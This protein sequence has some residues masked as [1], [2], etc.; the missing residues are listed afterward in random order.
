[1]CGWLAGLR[2]NEALDLDWQEKDK[3]P[4]LDLAHSR[5]VF[6]FDAVDG[7]GQREVC[8]ITVSARARDLAQAADV[9]LTMKSLRRGFGCR[10]AVRPPAQVL[11]KLTRHANINTTLDYYA[12]VDDAVMEAVLGPRRN[13]PRNRPAGA[14]NNAEATDA[15]SA[16]RQTTSL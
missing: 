7:R 6:R 9:K 12:N 15:A 5:K 10:Y 2:L 8:D 14:A 3:A 16:D 1:L 13:T 11:Q 4:F